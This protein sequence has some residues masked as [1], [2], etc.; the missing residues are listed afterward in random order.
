MKCPKISAPGTG[1]NYHNRLDTLQ[2]MLI[3]VSETAKCGDDFAPWA[4]RLI[5]KHRPDLVWLDPLF[6]FIGGSVSDQQTA[7][8][9]LRKNLGSIAQRTGVVWMIVHHTNKPPGDPAQSNN[10]GI[11]SEYA[12]L[13][14]GSAELANWARAVLTLREVSD[15]LFELRASKRGRRAGLLDND[16]LPATEIFWAHG[17]TGICW[18]R[19]SADA[20]SAIE[21]A[22]KA[23]Q[24]AVLEALKAP[25]ADGLGWRYSSII[26]LIVKIRGG[27]ENGAK[28]WFRRNLAPQLLETSGIYTPKCCKV[29]SGFKAG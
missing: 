21:G 3:F 15:A 19:A 12:Y 8:K 1:T 2:S 24:K 17:K 13:G 10:R 14:S 25:S 16:G 26:E 5:E 4:E 11:G 22:T 18:E 29:S 28:S 9:F 7:S 6:A 20:L 23:E 27:K